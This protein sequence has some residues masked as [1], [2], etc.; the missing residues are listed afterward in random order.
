MGE[1]AACGRC[2]TVV[3]EGEL[4]DHGGASVCD[5][6]LAVNDAYTN[7]NGEKVEQTLFIDVQAWERIAARASTPSCA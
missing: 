1:A 3:G 6:R 5:F 2:G 4:L 7:R